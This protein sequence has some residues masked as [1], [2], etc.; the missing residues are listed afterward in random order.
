[1]LTAGGSFSPAR[2]PAP[3]GLSLARLTKADA[4]T[5]AILLDE[6]DTCSSES[7]FDEIERLWITRIA[8]YLDVI[9]GVSMKTSRF[10]K[11]ANSPI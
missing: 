2:G 6:V 9:D 1:L 4:Y 7:F 3:S 11:V 10:R 5:T 8:A